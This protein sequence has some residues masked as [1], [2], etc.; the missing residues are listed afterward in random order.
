MFI[1][2]FKFYLNEYLE[3]RINTMLNNIITV[4]I[5]KYFVIKNINNKYLKY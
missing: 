2:L 4:N 3:N 5:A 1:L